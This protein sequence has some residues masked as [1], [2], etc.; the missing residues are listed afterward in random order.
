VSGQENYC[1][2][3][4]TMTYGSMEPDGVT[5][6]W[7]GYAQH[8][9]VD[10]HF[11][12]TLPDGLDPAAS[13]PLLCAGIT[14]FTP[15]REAGI[16]NGS[17]VAVMGL[18]G[19]GHMAVK[20]A[21][22]FGAEVTVLSRSADKEGDARKLGAH[23][24]VLTSKAGALESLAGRSD[25]VVDTIS[26]KHD[27]TP[28]INALKPGGTLMLLGA[29]AEP[30]EFSP[31]PLLFGGKRIVGSLVGNIAD[32]QVM[33]DHCGRHGIVSDIELIAPQQINEAY[34]RTL[35]GDVKYRFVIDCSK[36]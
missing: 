6:T 1:E 22:S 9:V 2:K 4:V 30:L 3:G 16:T 17:R 5:P 13:A 33:L 24:F 20:L 28:A 7:G 32:T 36:F 21:A 34:E 8:I 27:L 29:A 14:T 12:F 25:G 35:K 10:D 18:G 23:E 26:A 31:L 11:V 19:L 15:L